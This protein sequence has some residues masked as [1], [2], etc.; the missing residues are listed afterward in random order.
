[1][2]LRS[3]YE[4]DEL[5]YEETMDQETANDPD[6]F[7]EE[8]RRIVE[9]RRRQD[10]EIAE[11]AK[12]K[13]EP[14]R[15]Q[16]SLEPE[17]LEESMEEEPG[18]EPSQPKEEYWPD[19]EH[20]GMLNA[21]ATDKEIDQWCKQYLWAHIHLSREVVTL[22]KP[23]EIMDH[24]FTKLEDDYP[25]PQL[26]TDPGWIAAPPEIAKFRKELQTRLINKWKDWKQL[27]EHFQIGLQNDPDAAELAKM[28]KLREQGRQSYI[29]FQTCRKAELELK[30]QL[31]EQGKLEQTMEVVYDYKAWQ[32]EF[33]PSPRGSLS[34]R[35][36][37]KRAREEAKEKA[38]EKKRWK[39]RGE[40]R[41]RP[42][43][44]TRTRPELGS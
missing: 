2:N 35:E 29:Q 43:T 15:S 8:V 33:P 36:K 38:K 17:E 22:R 20:P 39:K 16:S 11:A 10:K 6:D 5:D 13:E 32:P 34:I 21:D 28:R 9:E 3:L 24:V 40:A 23:K 7:D 14:M 26:D 12:E 31:K 44:R 25:D 30:Q 27:A 1:M 19:V 37:E 18:P 42:G 41:D 4:A